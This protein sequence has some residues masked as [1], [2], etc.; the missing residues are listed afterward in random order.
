MKK[1]YTE[2]IKLLQLEESD[3]KIIAM[4]SNIVGYLKKIIAEEE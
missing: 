3:E 2:V 1:T 4:L